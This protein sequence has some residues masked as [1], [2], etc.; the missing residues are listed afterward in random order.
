M[1]VFGRPVVLPAVFVAT[2]ATFAG[3]QQKACEPD[4]N[5]P[6]QVARAVLQLQLA[7]GATKPEDAA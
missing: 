6:N 3:A 4:E 1:H 7:Q 2:M 5:A